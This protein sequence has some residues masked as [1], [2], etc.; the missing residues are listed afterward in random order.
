MHFS[1]QVGCWNYIFLNEYIH[2]VSL[3]FVSVSGGSATWIGMIK[4]NGEWA[5]SDNMAVDYTNFEDS[6]GGMC[7]YSS[8]ALWYG[9]NCNNYLPFACKTEQS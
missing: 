3:F 9:Q 6:D 4:R 7:A 8:D 5:W 1:L 2:N